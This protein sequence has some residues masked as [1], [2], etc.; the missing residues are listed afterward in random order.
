LESAVLA[1]GLPRAGPCAV[2]AADTPELDAAAVEQVLDVAAASGP[3][4][5]DLPRHPWAA[6]DAAL[7][8]LSFVVL[9]VRADVAGLVAAH[10]AVRGLPDV[11]LGVLVRR[12]A[13]HP[14]SCAQLLGV[15]L[16][17][18][19]PPLHSGAPIDPHRL[20]RTTARVAAGLFA[21]LGLQ[22]D[23]ALRVVR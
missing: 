4:V 22:T 14:E 11:P 21:G 6:R 1:E 15:P 8:Y 20:P 12:G 9:L 2:L 17:G 13:V 3:V 18:S 19:L 16:L 7:P 5:V 23:A 10:T